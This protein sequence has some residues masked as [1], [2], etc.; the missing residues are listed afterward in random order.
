MSQS[1]FRSQLK[2]SQTPLEHQIAGYI[3]DFFMDN[4][5]P[6]WKIIGPALRKFDCQRLYGAT[7]LDDEFLKIL[8]KDDKVLS[9]MIPELRFR[10]HQLII[11]LMKEEYNLINCQRCGD[12]SRLVAYNFRRRFESAQSLDGDWE[13]HCFNGINFFQSFI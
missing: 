3:Q 7:T 6:S 9:K 5:A 1:R 4:K 8:F 10:H 12:Y 13:P 2:M 11:L